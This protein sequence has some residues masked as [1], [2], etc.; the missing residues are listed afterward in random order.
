L[1]F[2]DLHLT[3]ATLNHAAGALLV[4]FATGTASCPLCSDG[5]S[6]KTDYDRGVAKGYLVAAV[7]M[8]ILGLI[9]GYFCFF[10]V[11]EDMSM[12]ALPGVCMC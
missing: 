5:P 11:K 9:G 3:A 7:I 10:K 6:P 12:V 1:S 4:K 8:T 2:S